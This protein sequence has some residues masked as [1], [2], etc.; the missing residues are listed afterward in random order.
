MSM[1]GFSWWQAD[2]RQQPPHVYASTSICIVSLSSSL[3]FA[4]RANT[5]KNVEECMHLQRRATRERLPCQFIL[6]FFDL[7]PWNLEER[8]DS[9]YQRARVS[10]GLLKAAV[11]LWCGDFHP[12]VVWRQ[13]CAAAPSAALLTH[14]HSTA[15]GLIPERPRLLAHCTG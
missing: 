6:F 9:F 8:C 3:F 5:A 14:S 11:S 13:T 10:C 1:R 4:V 7:A 15:A 2:R 12:K